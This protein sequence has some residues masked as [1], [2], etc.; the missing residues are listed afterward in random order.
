MAY[1]YY[2]GKHTDDGNLQQKLCSVFG[3]PLMK[4]CETLSEFSRRLHEPLHDVQAAVVLINDREELKNI[5]SWKDILWEIKL[6]VIFSSKSDIT[7]AEVMALRPRFLTWTNNDLTQVVN[8]LKKMMQGGACGKISTVFPSKS[9]S[10]RDEEKND[11][12]G[13]SKH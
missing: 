4:R 8:V 10:I 11:Q 7:Q 6:I 12:P 2:A 1:I 3:A 5:L 9:D 13:K